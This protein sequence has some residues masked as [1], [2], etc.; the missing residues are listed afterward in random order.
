[1]LYVQIALCYLVAAVTFI[2]SWLGEQPGA[3][4]AAYLDSFA[5]ANALIRKK[6]ELSKSQPKASAYGETKSTPPN[7]GKAPSKK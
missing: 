7:G 1:M 6:I 5:E 3:A 4:R 2:F